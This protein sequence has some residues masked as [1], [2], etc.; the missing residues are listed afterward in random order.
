MGSGQDAAPAELQSCFLFEV[1]RVLG[2]EHPVG[3][4]LTGADAEEVAGEARA[5]GVDV[6]EGWAFLWGYAGAHRALAAG[7]SGSPALCL[8]F[9]RRDE[10]T[11]LS[12]MP[13]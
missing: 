8:W 2:I 13:L 11:M 5:V 12:P 3:E 6:V 4:G 9:I 1:V 7:V 10:L